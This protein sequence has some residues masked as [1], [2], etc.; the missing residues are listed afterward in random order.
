MRYSNR[1]SI[2]KAKINKAIYCSS[3]SKQSVLPT[4]SPNILNPHPRP[5]SFPFP[6]STKKRVWL[7]IFSYNNYGI[8]NS[9]CIL[10]TDPRRIYKHRDSITRHSTYRKKNLKNYTKRKRTLQ[11]SSTGNSHSL[12]IKN[13]C[14]V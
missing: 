3:P 8:K 12:S 1:Q 4:K 14:A 6:T 11:N 2:L 9:R 5:S 7:S 13:V 10:F